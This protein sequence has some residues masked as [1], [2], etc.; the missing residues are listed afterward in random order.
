M[1]NIITTLP[2]LDFT[3]FQTISPSTYILIITALIFIVSAGAEAIIF[4][5]IKLL[6]YCETAFNNLDLGKPSF[7]KEKSNDTG[8]K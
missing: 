4:I 1:E 2:P 3:I 8:I 5:F 7:K 6:E